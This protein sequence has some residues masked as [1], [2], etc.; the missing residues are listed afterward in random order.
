MKVSSYTASGLATGTMPTMSLSVNNTNKVTKNSFSKKGKRKLNYSPRE[1]SSAILRAGK[2]QSAARV[3]VQAKGKLNNLMRCKGSGQYNEGELNMAIAHAKRMVQCA[4][5]KARNL[6]QE[7]QSR[8]RYEK[9]AKE[10]LSRE[11]NEIKAKV[12]RKEQ[13]LEQKS[14]IERMQR[15]QKQKSQKRELMRKKKFHRSRERGKLNEADM[16]YLRQQLRGLREPYSASQSTAAATLELSIPGM[17]LTEIQIEQQI[18]AQ[19]NGEGI[20][21]GVEG[22]E[23]NVQMGGISST[24]GTS[25]VNVVV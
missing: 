4:Q 25:A 14:N 12:G 6:R 16:D 11:K 8:K 10:E 9:E 1:M 21:T 5:M 20:N 13:D 15:V 18:A 24:A 17:Q 22:G 23:T 3:A 2:S 19:M 7:E